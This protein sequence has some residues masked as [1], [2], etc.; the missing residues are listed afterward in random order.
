MENMKFADISV[1]DIKKF[2]DSRGYFMETF[3]QKRYVQ[4]G[5]TDPFV[6]DNISMSSC[7]VLR[8]LHYQISHP[9]G[10][11]VTVL[12][13]RVFDVV[14]DL[15]KSSPTFGQWM[16]ITLSAD[17]G[18]QL[19]IPPGF[20]HGFLVEEDNTLFSYKCTEFYHPAAERTLLWNDP[21]IDINWPLSRVAPV[22]SA[23]DAMGTLFVDAEVYL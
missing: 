13:G 15:R 12:Q 8:G 19:W 1:F 7:G 21:T 9:Q 18:K 22:I 11:L 2:S 10:K 3:Q 23:K 6:Q 14:V 20:A 4:A 5:I 16:G 17:N